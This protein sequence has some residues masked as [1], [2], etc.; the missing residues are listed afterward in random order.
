MS[1]S[2]FLFYRDRALTS[3]SC[4]TY[5]KPY[6]L[7]ATSPTLAV[8]CKLRP[9]AH[10][11]AA[12]ALQIMSSAH[13]LTGSRASCSESVCRSILRSAKPLSP[14]VQTHSASLSRFQRSRR[15]PDSIRPAHRMVVTASSVT[16]APQGI[17]LYMALAPF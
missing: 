5:Q 7:V 9:A 3:Q 10:S 12:S 11:H 6:K 15:A 13:L 14:S 8:R 2:T 17:A 1:T 16:T 4:Q